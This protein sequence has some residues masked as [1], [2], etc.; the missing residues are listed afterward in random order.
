[1]QFASA[2]LTRSFAFLVFTLHMFLA[3]ATTQ[4]TGWQHHDSA[5]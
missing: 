1:M 4:Y 3:L 2:E 5:Q